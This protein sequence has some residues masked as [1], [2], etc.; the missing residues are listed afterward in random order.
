MVPGVPARVLLGNLEPVVAL[1]MTAVLEERGL[2]VI[3]CEPRLQPL[4]LLAGQLRPDAVVLDLHG[5][6]SHDLAGRLR[7]AAPGAE[8]VLW[9]RDEEVMDVGGRRIASPTPDDLSAAL[10]GRSIAAP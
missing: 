2:E 7:A 1:G 8:I 10:G 4:L 5:A 6:E 3:G 9:A